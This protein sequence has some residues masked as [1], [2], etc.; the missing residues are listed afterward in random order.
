LEDFQRDREFS[1]HTFAVTAGRATA[2]NLLRVSYLLLVVWTIGLLSVTSVGY[3][4]SPANTAFAL[5]FLAMTVV[6]I[7]LF[8]VRYHT[9]ILA[10]YRSE[11]SYRSDE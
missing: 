2:I 10:Q 6:A 11:T 3:A 4:M 7:L 8:Y 1:V 5:S 9:D